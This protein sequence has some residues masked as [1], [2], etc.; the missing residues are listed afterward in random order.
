MK[1]MACHASLLLVDLLKMYPWSQ[2]EDSSIEG[3]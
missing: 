1:V 2:M 3:T